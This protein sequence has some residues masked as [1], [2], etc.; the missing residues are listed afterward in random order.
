MWRW[1]M[2]GLALFNCSDKRAKLDSDDSLF[3]YGRKLGIV[4]QRIDEA[5]GLV[6]SLTNPGYLW[7]VNDS[8]NPAEAFLID[9]LAQIKLVCKL[10]VRNRDWE[11]IAVGDGPVPGKKYLYVGDIGDNLGIY[12]YKYI[13]RFEEPSI[14]NGFNQSITN[15]DTLVVRLPDGKRD[16]ETLMMDP[17]NNDLYIISKREKQV[18]IYLNHFPFA[19]TVRPR[20]VLT[21]PFTKIVA[22][23]IS[24]DGTEVLL[25]NYDSVF[26]WKRSGEK[27]IV[28]LLAKRPIRMPYEHEFQGEAICWRNDASGYYTLSES[29]EGRMA[30]L[31]F[32]KRRQK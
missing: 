4:D 9:S 19:D 18:N 25:K 13:Y 23:S 29:H 11:D 26:Y 21:I 20:K 7:T 32:Y 27:S 12:K 14:K 6:A 5:S 31:K 10:D 30:Y 2:I 22:G 24:G 3:S 8:G 15:F 17:T 16:A 28:E 1:M